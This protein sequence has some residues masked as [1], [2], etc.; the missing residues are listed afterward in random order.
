MARS[1]SEVGETEGCSVS[2][3]YTLSK[4]F[5]RFG[6]VVQA[7]VFMDRETKRSRGFGF[8]TFRKA[9]EAEAA[10]RWPRI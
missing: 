6:L 9:R 5:S 8:V 10:M 3:L 2:D 4:L 1:L 7:M